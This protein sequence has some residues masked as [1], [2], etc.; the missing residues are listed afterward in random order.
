MK[1][2]FVIWISQA[3]SMLANTI[4][5]FA[6]AWYLT[7]KTGSATILSTSMMM[8][9]IPQVALGSFIGPFIDRWSRK[10]I[11]IYSDIAQSLLSLVLVVLF[12]TKN[13]QIW[14]IYVVMAGSS[15][16]RSFQGPALSASIPMVVTEKHLVRAN[17][18]NWTLSGFINII[19]PS[20]GALLM[21]VFP[22]QWV[23]SVDAIS[24]IIFVGCLLPLAIPQPTRSV[25]VGKPG[26]FS[27]M[28]QGFRYFASWRGLLY[29]II[30][31]SMLM[32]FAA[33]INALRPLFVTKYFGSDVLKLGWLGTVASIGAIAGGLILGAWG[34][35]KRRII[36]TL[37]GIMVQGITAVIFG[38]TTESLFFL[39]LAM[40]FISGLSGA[41]LNGNI[42]AI[43]QSA[44]AKDMQGRV[45]SLQYSLSG[46]MT[47]LALAITGPAVGAI[48][49]RTIWYVSGAMIFILTGVAFFSRDLINIENRKVIEE[50]QAEEI[51]TLPETKS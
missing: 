24:T 28:K 35:F 44:V 17:G 21:K 9:L 32:F 15:T 30:L 47:P 45:V 1:K 38:F 16:S 14:H 36:T 41:I 50:K 19:G 49:L 37:I 22:M 20:A 12:Y 26:Y 31:I 8:N 29:L 2:F 34:G 7:Q 5:G 39:A 10:K 46:L 4:V 6:L 43:I 13:I 3:S 27:D 51:P 23:L 18:L 48:G 33:P 40:V 11:M 42:G 25:S